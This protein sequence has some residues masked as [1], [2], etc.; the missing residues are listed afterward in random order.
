MFNNCESSYEPL[1]I[2]D[3]G[4][5]RK[6]DKYGIEISTNDD[7]KNGKVGF[8]LFDRKLLDNTKY[9]QYKSLQL[10]N[11]IFPPISKTI[12]EK[13]F[14]DFMMHF[15]GY[16]G[17]DIYLFQLDDPLSLELGYVAMCG[18]GLV[19]HKIGILKLKEWQ[20]NGP[21]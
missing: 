9:T 11:N 6:L 12:I 10:I 21:K 7:L 5:K 8:V 4:L 2:I 14:S 19:H 1:D 3:K 13:S 16:K 17:K 18:T 15:E 20:K